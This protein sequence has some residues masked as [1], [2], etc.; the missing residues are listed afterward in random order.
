MLRNTN[1]NTWIRKGP[2]RTA[3]QDTESEAIPFDIQ[4]FKHAQHAG[5]SRKLLNRDIMPRPKRLCGPNPR[6]AG[7]IASTPAT[8]RRAKFRLQRLADFILRSRVRVHLSR[9]TVSQHPGSPKPELTLVSYL[10]LAASEGDV[11]EAP[12]EQVALVGAAL[13]RLGLPLGLNLYRS[14][15]DSAGGSIWKR[16]TLGVCDLT[17]PAR[18][19]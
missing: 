18:S 3:S 15:N 16:R 11:D 1:E 8:S 12:S 7:N 17:L 6:L 10:P 13:G 2:R 14:V 19:G 5:K 9:N 4:H